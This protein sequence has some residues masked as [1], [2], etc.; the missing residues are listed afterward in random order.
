MERP[1]T[2]LALV[3][4]LYG[5]IVAPDLAAQDPTSCY[6]LIRRGPPDLPTAREINRL[7]REMAAR[8]DS[9]RSVLVAQVIVGGF[10]DATREFYISA[11]DVAGRAEAFAPTDPTVLLTAARLYLRAATMGEARVDTVLGL[12]AQC[13]ARR[14]ASTSA[15]PAF[16]DSAKTLLRDI[17]MSLDEERRAAKYDVKQP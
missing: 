7:A 13:F 2:T 8:A 6:G 12:R 1:L 9:S 14:A 3:G 16:A 17:Q 11:A 15:D 4:I 5:A 10:E